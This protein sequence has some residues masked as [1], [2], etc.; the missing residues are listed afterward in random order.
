MSQSLPLAAPSPAEAAPSL[1]ERLSGVLLRPTA[2]F[3]RMT[4]ADAW[5]WPA[6]FLITGYTL[7]Y[8]AVGVGG[9]RWQIGWMSNLLRSSTP[10][11]DPA[12]ERAVQGM[13][14]WIA[15]ASQLFGN[16]VQVPILVALSWS[17]RSLTF[18]GL[19]RLFGGEK[20]FWGRVVAMVGWAWLPLFVQYAVTGVL[21]L[22]FPQVMSFILPLPAEQQLGNAA[23]SLRANWIGPMLFYVSPFVIWNLCLCT[24]GVAEL[25]RL[26]RWKATLVVLLPAVA[27][28]LF[29]LLG[30][31]F[32]ATM[33]Q[34]LSHPPGTAPAPG[35]T[36]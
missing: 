9:A 26:P 13:F 12:A 36:P 20:P 28:L 22:I 27:Q 4:D 1:R 7:Y 8:L 17:L 33:M 34:S 11:P 32:S 3:A 19:A 15:P 2:S 21:M 35:N 25:F 16:V 5:F 29:L 6:I 24:L 30:Y 18:Y 23:Q 14:V 10:N 31:Y